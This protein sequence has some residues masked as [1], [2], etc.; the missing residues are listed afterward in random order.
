[1]TPRTGLYIAL[2]GLV[3]FLCGI[4]ALQSELYVSIDDHSDFYIIGIFLLQGG[5]FLGPV[6]MVVGLIMA[7][8][9]IVAAQIDQ[10]PVEPKE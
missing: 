6:V 8:V 2:I 5:A 10:L 9:L 3:I 1:M 4:A 7:G